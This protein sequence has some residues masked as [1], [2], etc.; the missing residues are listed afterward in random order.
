MEGGDQRTK[1]T[2]ATVMGL[3]QSKTPGE[4]EGG[5][6]GGQFKIPSAIAV[7]S[8]CS[9]NA[10]RR[11]PPSDS[12]Y[13]LR[14]MKRLK[15]NNGE[16]GGKA[17]PPVTLRLREDYESTPYNFNRNKKKRP[18]TIDENQFATLNPTY[19]TDIIKKQQ[20]PSVSAASVLRKH[21]ANADTQYRKRFSH[22]N[23]AK[24]STVNLKARDYTPLSVLR[25][26]VKGPKHLKSSCDTVTE[27]NVVKRNFSSIDKWVKLEKPP[28]YFA[29]AE[30]DTNIAAGLESPFHLIRQAAKLGLISDVQDV[31]S[32]Y[33]TIKQSCID[34][35]EKAS[36]FLW[37]NNRTKQPPSSWWPV[38]FGS[39][40]LSVL[41]TSPLLNWNRLCKNNGK[42]WIKT[43]SIDHM[44][45]NVFKLSPGAC[46]SILE[47][48]TTLL[49][50]VTAQC[51]KWESYR[52]NIPVPAHVQ[53]EYASQVVMIGPSELY[54][55]V[56]V[57]VYY[58]L[59]TGK[60][61]KF[62]T[63]K[64]MYCE[65]VFETVFSHALEGRMKGAV[66]VRKMCVEGFCVEMDFAGISVIDVLNGDLKCKM[67]EN[68]VQQPNPSTTSSKPAAELMQD[69][70]SLCRMRDTLYGVRMLQATGRLPEGLQSKCKK[71]IT[72]SISAIAIVGK[73]RER[74]LNQLPFVLVEIVNIVT[75]LSQQGLVNPDIKSDNIVIDGITGQPKM[76][77]FGLIVPCKKY[78][79]FKCW[80]TDE[81]FFS[82]HPHT[83]PE[84]INSELCSE[85]AMTFGLA[86]LLIDM[87]SILIK[88]TADLSANSIYT[89]IPFLSIVSKM[90]DQ[91][92][93]NRPRA[94]EI[95]PVIGACFP[96]KDNIAKLFQS[97]NIHCIARRL[98]RSIKYGINFLNCFIFLLL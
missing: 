1:L 44:A 69:H 8:C 46:E 74:M 67:D 33:E 43:M 50:E 84:F 21:R 62:M 98:S 29:V 94:Y 72:D 31:S 45:K 35:K 88:R 14:P 57:G 80:G 59:E 39:K 90:Y 9:K 77:D 12:P 52:R 27:T 25:S 41:D 68:V 23:C 6:G 49:G 3:Y 66:G 20:L 70:G 95:A 83:A 7:K 28:C 93:T 24:F 60:V 38:G 53:P 40:N 55:E 92:K 4:G 2:P 58:M 65:F 5:E 87:L 34:A 48:K 85:T 11:S 81:R 47:K 26:H 30:A 18:I 42:G 17:P 16:V 89:N 79:N 56:K 82:N 13:S 97:P 37:S 73:M 19:A 54:L 75:R 91:E 64:E 76:I 36:K 51:K 10:T 63:D 86:Y 32:N 22:P 96:F 61:I 78:Y 71:P 15:K